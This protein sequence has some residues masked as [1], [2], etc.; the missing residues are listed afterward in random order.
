MS[1]FLKNELQWDFEK[2]QSLKFKLTTTTNTDNFNNELS[3][4][5]FNTKNHKRKGFTW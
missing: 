3:L 4:Q 1:S 5:D 2:I